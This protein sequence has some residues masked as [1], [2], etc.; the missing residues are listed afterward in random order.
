MEFKTLLNIE[1]SFRQIR[2]FTLIFS[3]LVTLLAVV[4]IFMSYRFA[5]QQRQ[6][7][8]V[9]E[10]GNSLQLALSRDVKQN[11]LVQ[12]RYHVKRFHELF[13]TLDPDEEAINR[14]LARAFYMGD[15]SISRLHNDLKESGFYRHIISGNIS[16]RIQVDSIRVDFSTPPLRATAYA[17]QEIIRS[18]SVTTRELISTCQLREV[19]MTDNNPMGFLIEHYKVISN[20][21][22]KTVKRVP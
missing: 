3:G 16:Q 17:R 5:E 4:T 8:Y 20:R 1:S 12:A 13:Y 14:N 22:L 11:R 18:T 10:N 7:I 15:E 21:D 6:K 2:L 19:S 9:L